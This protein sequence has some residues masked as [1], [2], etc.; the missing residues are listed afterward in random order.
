ME[1][2][3]PRNGGEGIKEND[4]GMNST[5]INCKNFCNCHNVSPSTTIIKKIRNNPIKF[6]KIFL[7]KK[8]PISNRGFKNIWM[9]DHISTIEL[10]HEKNKYVPSKSLYLPSRY[11]RE[12]QDIMAIIGIQLWVWG[13]RLIGK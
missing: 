6:L 8:D 13:I 1:K 9:S 2:M 10:N 3:R 4:G 7:K 5:M 12:T 11:R